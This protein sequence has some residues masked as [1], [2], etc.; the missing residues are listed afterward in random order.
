MLS[1]LGGLIAGTWHQV[2]GVARIG[3]AYYVGALIGL[4]VI[5]VLRATN[6][7]RLSGHLLVAGWTAVFTYVAVLRGGLWTAPMLIMASAPMLATTTI[8]RSAGVG[9]FCVV[10]A[11]ASA[12]GLAPELG[13]ELTDHLPPDRLAIAR[14]MGAIIFFGFAAGIALALYDRTQDALRDAEKAE[15]E[16][17]LAATEASLLRTERMASIGRLAAGTAHE[18]NNP[19]TYVIFNLEHLKE[20]LP[21]EHQGLVESVEEA[22]DGALRIRR[23]VQ[24]LKTFGR[25]DEEEGAADVRVALEKAI[26]I[27]EP[28]L[29]HRSV[30]RRRIEEVPLVVGDEP[31]LTQ[32][33]LNLLLNALQAFGDRTDGTIEVEVKKVGDRVVT[34]VRDDGPGIPDDILDKVTEP[35]FTTKPIGVGTGLGLSVSSNLVERQGG[36]LELESEAGRG[37]TVRVALR[38]S[39]E[40]LA[41]PERPAPQQSVESVRARRVLICDDDRLLTKAMARILRDHHVVLV[42]SGEAALEVLA[43]DRRW[44]LI[45]CDVMM[46]GIDG[47]EVHARVKKAWPELE[48]RMVFM[49]GG[50]FTSR[51]LEFVSDVAPRFLHKPVEAEM[52]RNLVLGE[53]KSEVA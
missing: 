23:I 38:V 36:R 12:L 8:G 44:D 35:F 19:L 45:L 26:R 30:L 37:T 27:A 50:T 40:P 15:R 51:A 18:I 49:S 33:F 22:L 13:Y 47:V 16:R 43:E 21:P 29:S 9:W 5:V 11:C 53:A 25:E 17:V 4:I 39:S 2:L 42:T 34:E 41:V 24:D 3:N 1:A 52:L 32:V 46:P 20:Q 7:W 14:V 28:Q 10:A 31:R 48:P 6:R